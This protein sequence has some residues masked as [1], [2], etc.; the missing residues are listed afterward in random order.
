MWED[1]KTTIWVSTEQLS[2]NVGTCNSPTSSP[3]STFLEPR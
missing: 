1:I 2:T 3:H